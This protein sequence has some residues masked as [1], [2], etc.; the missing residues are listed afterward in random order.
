V[1][2]IDDRPTAAPATGFKAQVTLAF[3]DTFALV[4][5]PK[6]ALAGAAA[7]PILV[8]FLHGMLDTIADAGIGV[9]IP[10]IRREFELTLEE[11]TRIGTLAGVLALVVGI[12]LGYRTDRTKNRIWWLAGGAA[13]AS[14]FFVLTGFAGTVFLF[15]SGRFL[16]GLGLKANDPVQSSLLADYT[17]LEARP[18]VY[19]S[20][21]VI[22]SLGKV[23]GPVSF[24][25]I[26]T[27]AS[28]RWAFGFAGALA[29]VV[30][31]ISLRL[32]DPPRG[33]QERLAMGV[34][35]EDAEV[36]EE[37]PRFE[38]AY[39]IL[40][41]VGTV[42]RL[43]YAIPFLTGGL[44]SF[45]FFVPLF[46]E[47][48]FGLN[49]AERGFVLGFNEPFA[50]I[51]LV[52]GIPVATRALAGRTPQR[53]FY[54]LGAAASVIAGL[55]LAYALAPNVA[56]VLVI[57]CVYAL[58]GSILLPGLSTAFSLILPPRARGLGFA[59]M[60]IW[61]IPGVLFLIPMGI[62]GD[63]HGARWGMAIG[64]PV[65]LLGGLILGSAGTQFR[66]D[67]LRARLSSL[68]SLE[69]KKAK[70]AGKPKMLVCRGVTVHYGQVQVLFGV[71][72]DVEEGEM[73]ALLGTNGAGKSTLLKAISGTV[74]PS[75]GA[76]LLDG[77][78]ITRAG[79]VMT[80]EL[81]IVQMPGGRSVFPTLT[82]KENLEVATWL[83]KGDRKEANAATEK[84]LDLFPILRQK[85]GDEAGNLSGGQ[86]QMLGLA[87]AFICRPRLLMIDELSLG[88]APSIVQQLLDI[89]RAIHAQGTTV[90]LVEQS[91]NVALSLCERA[92][93]LEKGEVR[94]EG[95]TED[96]LEREDV[97]RSVFLEGASAAL[98]EDVVDVRP[99]GE[100]GA[101]AASDLDIIEHAFS[102]SAMA[103]PRMDIAAMQAQGWRPI[104]AL[105]TQ[106][107]RKRFGGIAAV[108]GVSFKLYQGEI[109]GL[110]GS[111]GAGKTTILDLIS[112]FTPLDSGRVLLDGTDVTDWTPD[113]RAQARLGRSFQAA[114]L[115]PSLTVKE[116]IAVALERHIAMR[117]PFSL[118][119][120]SISPAA[121]LSELAV[122]QR[123]EELIELMAIG[124]FRDKFISELSTGS[125]RMVDIAC[126]LA[127][128]PKV[129]L[130][131][132]PS[133]GIAQR[134]T[135]QLGP[136]LQRIQQE[137]GASLL[138]I[139]HDMPLI[140]SIAD[141]MVALELGAVIAEGS[142]QA[143]LDDPRVVASY[144][145]MDTE[146]SVIQRSGASTD[147]LDP[148][149][150]KGGV[151]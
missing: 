109:L 135:E 105:E 75:N 41:G 134:E 86:Q 110:I 117:D 150:T 122:Q 56:A 121:R 6:A 127:H 40:K 16:L 68:A 92:I 125:R 112:G 87:Q 55:I 28:W 141:R 133:S 95:R 99:G 108:D 44:L 39:Q 126:S 84:V 98:G 115:F 33:V 15:I 130:L 57:S 32:K 144:L 85:L 106:E 24:G 61:A 17:P 148:S 77:R 118:A 96:L 76:I 116:V 72:F 50:V 139:E 137:L 140:T 29:M 70:A 26:G 79:P 145:G 8:I 38:E 60:G 136:L 53:L 47:E 49:A 100:G 103:R 114:T 35:R 101:P 19:S 22:G 124:A 74:L 64:A 23:I 13:F 147:S 34:D 21:G 104:V 81:G 9:V 151:A 48:T 97:L 142:P 54:L 131:D 7:L 2:A 149:G 14:V 62:V 3:R 146:A 67:M 107:L 20:R 82:V 113:Q 111:N 129:L 45:G 36:E 51:G 18:A 80:S 43:W 59:I 90:V 4:R 94:F 78:D 89:V 71:D 138:V 31:I 37:H 93:F 25:V 12:P 102:S 11:I 42:R 46:L 123:V 58:V 73:V 119:F 120:Q 63:A 10:D 128:D 1:T 65:F 88:L 27:L 91:V 52:L 143:V 132:E 66:A 83:Y 5:H 69:V 30:A